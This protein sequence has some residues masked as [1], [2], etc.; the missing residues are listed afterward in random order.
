MSEVSSYMWMA[1]GV[2]G[3]GIGVGASAVVGVPVTDYIAIG[4]RGAVSE[5]VLW[6]LFGTRP[7]VYI[8]RM[9]DAGPLVGLRLQ[10]R[11]GQ[12]SLASGVVGVR[13]RRKTLES[14]RYTGGL[15]GFCIFC[16]ERIY[17]TTRFWTVGLPID[18]QVFLI[19]SPHFGLGFHGYMTVTPRENMWGVSLQLVA[20]GPL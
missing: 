20:R 9:W 3:S 8:D 4:G 17:K 12:L 6:E 5:F 13:G 14:V 7:D 15:G 11:Y 19:T 10:G 18:A 16:E 1:G 2:G